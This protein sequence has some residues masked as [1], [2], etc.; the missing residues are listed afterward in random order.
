MSENG[1]MPFPGEEAARERF[2]ARETRPRSR[3][4][5]TFE[6]YRDWFRAGKSHHWI[7]RRTGDTD[8]N[9]GYLFDTC[10]RQ[11]MFDGA[12]AVVR[13]TE[14][15]ARE[16][17]ER[18]VALEERCDDVGLLEVIRFLRAQKHEVELIPLRKDRSRHQKGWLRVDG[19]CW[20]IYCRVNTG[21]LRPEPPELHIFVRKATLKKTSWVVCYIDIAPYVRRIII[22]PSVILLRRIFIGFSKKR[23]GGMLRIALRPDTNT[24]WYANFHGDEVSLE[25]IIQAVT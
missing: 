23:R 6:Q 4:L 19:K 8:K 21:I 5:A 9:V 2:K 14:R 10:F 24:P 16:R 22:A 7:A 3:N 17:K 15:Y 13:R 20:R 1:A 12:T 25:R 11:Q 18:S